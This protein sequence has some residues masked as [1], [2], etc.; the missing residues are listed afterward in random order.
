M[1]AVIIAAG[2]GSRLWDKSNHIPKTLM[3]FRNETI[4]SK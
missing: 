1:K 2:M 3:P 4:L